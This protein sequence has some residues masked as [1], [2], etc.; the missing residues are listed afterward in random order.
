MWNN[1][2]I[3]F[4]RLLCEIMATQD[5]FDSDAVCKEMDISQDE[6]SELFN[7]AS[8]VWEGFKLGLHLCSN[9][10]STGVS[11]YKNRS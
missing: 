2:L 6:L 3:Q 8:E 5:N 4:A 1:N 9:Q 7:R 10:R 11:H